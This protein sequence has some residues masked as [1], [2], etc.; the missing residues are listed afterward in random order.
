MAGK[1][2]DVG[3]ANDVSQNSS[4]EVLGTVKRVVR[5]AVT[6]ADRTD[7]D[8]QLHALL[9]SHISVERQQKRSQKALAKLR[10]REK[11]I[12]AQIL[13]LH[14][15]RNEAVVEE[16]VS[17]RVERTATEI[18]IVQPNGDAI[19]ARPLTKEEISQ[20]DSRLP[21]MEEAAKV[22]HPE[23]DA[24]DEVATI[25]TSQAEA[26]ALRI[27]LANPLSFEECIADVDDESTETE[28]A[29]EEKEAKPKGKKPK[30]KGKKMKQTSMLDEGESDGPVH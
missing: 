3:P 9:D 20:L 22:H 30:G 28:A 27:K 19:Y 1:K 17:C 12:D 8:T 6:D 2:P 4:V 16:I 24:S 5:R 21:G 26:K 25:E 23:L 29:I 15:K 7:L 14:T 10:E 18:R 13:E 11:Q